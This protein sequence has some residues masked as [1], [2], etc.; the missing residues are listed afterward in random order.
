MLAND[1]QKPPLAFRHAICVSGATRDILVEA[2]IPISNARIIYT[3]LDVDKY[4]SGERTHQSD[5]NGSLN[6]L[7]AG[8][9]ASDK[10]IDTAIAAMSKLVHEQGRTGMR[11]SLAGSG[12]LEYE[13]YLH[14]L[15]DQAH[16]SD[17]VTFLGWFPPKEIPEL[18]RK[19]D[20]LLL[21]STWPEPFARVLL[22]GML[23]EL[24]VV[25]AQTGGTVE[26]VRDGEN[27]LLFAP[28][29]I[30]DLTQKITS[31]ADDPGLR[32]KIASAGHRTVFKRYTITKMLDEIESYLQEIMLASSEAQPV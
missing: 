30:D 27:G 11:M 9:L 14:H 16:L 29:N 32:R 24:V 17:Q 18:M 28:G 20:V 31:L 23:S 7:Y 6:L 8:R 21:P 12:P 10:G 15:V 3:G 22:E 26:V 1:A 13:S 25:A 4:S 19:F 5:D 2:G